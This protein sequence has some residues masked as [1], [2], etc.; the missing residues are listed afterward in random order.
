MDIS[1]YQP[2]ATDKLGV[3]FNDIQ[4]LALR[5]PEQLP[6]YSRPARSRQVKFDTVLHAVTFSYDGINFVPL[7]RIG[8]AL[9]SEA[10]FDT[11]YDGMKV[12]NFKAE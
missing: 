1:L 9:E 11:I 10:S 5:T 12:V 7:I 6:A 2:F 8:S 4:L 3:T